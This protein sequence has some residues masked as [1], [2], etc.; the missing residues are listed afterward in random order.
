MPDRVSSGPTCASAPATRVLAVLDASVDVM[1][2]FEAPG[3]FGTQDVFLDEV[4]RVLRPGGVLLLSTPNRDISSP[5]GADPDPFHVREL[6]RAAFVALLGSRFAHVA[7]APQRAAARRAI[8]PEHPAAPRVVFERSGNAR[9]NV[10]V[11]RQRASSAGL[12]F[13][14]RAAATADQ[15]ADP[16]R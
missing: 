11:Q 7:L 16:A 6:S 13:G 1:T 12:G 15:H 4:R 2:C 8:L 9:F 10:G 5:P 14:W 3:H